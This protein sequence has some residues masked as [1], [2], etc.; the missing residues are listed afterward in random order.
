MTE[1]I[2]PEINRTLSTESGNWT[3]DVGWSGEEFQGHT[4]YLVMS[5]DEFPVVKHISLHHPAIKPLPN[6]Q[7]TLS[8]RF[9]E[10]EETGNV[11]TVTYQLTDGVYSFE[12]TPGELF[13]ILE[14]TDMGRP[15]DIPADWNIENTTLIITIS[16]DEGSPEH[17]AFDDF[18]LNA[19]GIIQHL[20]VLGIG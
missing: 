1:R 3:G 17:I 8:F 14:W 4:G 6:K 2:Q 18:S 13:A 16:I 20:P 9:V 10:L 5:F 12:E 7:N 19:P 11:F 15:Y